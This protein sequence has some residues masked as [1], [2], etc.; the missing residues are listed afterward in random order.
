M[1]LLCKNTLVRCSEYHFY[2][3]SELYYFIPSTESLLPAAELII[4][5]GEAKKVSGLSIRVFH[6]V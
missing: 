4:T 6:I 2:V 3:N 1:I 5:L